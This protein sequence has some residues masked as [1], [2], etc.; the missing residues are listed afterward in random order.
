M[1]IGKSTVVSLVYEL[2]DLDGKLIEKTS[3][4]IAYL[5]GGFQGIFEAVEKALDGKALG[6]SVDVKLEPEEAFGDYDE[7]LVHL[8]PK[9]KFPGTIEVGME[10]EGQ[11]ESSKS[12]TIFRVTD[13]ADGK[14]VVDGNHPLAGMGLMF[15]CKIHDVRAATAEEVSHG[16]VHGPEGHQH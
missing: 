9:E 15:K 11:D 7:K 8:E 3:E 12:R 5:H 4:P 10:F 13:I 14:V 16:H 6:D 2:L 1:N